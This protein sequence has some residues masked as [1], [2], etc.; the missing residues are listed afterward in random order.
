MLKSH[1]AAGIR[2]RIAGA[3][4][5]LGASARGQAVGSGR[6][7]EAAA[8]SGGGGSSLGAR[9]GVEQE[10][11]GGARMEILLHEGLV[12]ARRKGCSGRH[13]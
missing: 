12:R 1:R 10:L 8:K 7:T 3:D 13:C 2:A 4:R 9:D 5:R 6:V 11:F